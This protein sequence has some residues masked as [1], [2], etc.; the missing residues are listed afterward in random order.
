MPILIDWDGKNYHEKSDIRKGDGRT[1]RPYFNRGVLSHGDL[2]AAVVPMTNVIQY[3]GSNEYAEIHNAAVDKVS[4]KLTM[5]ENYFEALYERKE[6]VKLATS[7]AKQLLNF[8]KNYRKPQYWRKVSKVAPTDLP[9][10]WLMYNFGV[11]PLV[12]TID[13]ALHVLS[14]DWPEATVRGLVTRT[15]T[16]TRVSDSPWITDYN[17]GE[18]RVMYELRA[19]VSP[20]F[21]PNGA[22]LNALGLT[23]PLST[24]SNVVPWGWAVNYFINVSDVLSNYESRFP[25]IHI[26]SVWRSVSCKGKFSTQRLRKDD[27]WSDK[28]KFVFHNGTFHNFYREPASMDYSLEFSVPSFG[29]NQFA[30][31]MSALAVTFAGTNKRK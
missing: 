25:G 12:G 21:N 8:A 1:E 15:L 7:A 23:T 30:N 28:G 19:H 26:K 9:S 10:A 14:R 31:L 11:K 16:S 13:S 24:L 4:D 20:N 27:I 18:N 2:S 6:A 22:L 29:T 17:Q 5:I 3:A